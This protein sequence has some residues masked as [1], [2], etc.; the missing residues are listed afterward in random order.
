MKM[1]KFSELKAAAMAATPGPWGIN[2]AGNK[3]VSNQSHPVATV[4]DAFHRQ[5]A[6][7][8][9]GKDAEFI[10]AANPAAVLELL[11]ER[12]ADKKRIAELEHEK[13]NRGEGW[14]P[15]TDPITGS[16]FFMWIA[17]PDKGMVPTYGGPYDSYTLAERDKDGSYWVERY[18]HDNGC[19]RGQDM[20]IED[21][22]V[23]VVDD[24]LYVSEEDPDDLK[25]EITE[26]REKLA[27][28]VRLTDERTL[29][30]GEDDYDTGHVKGWNANR[31]EQAALLKKQGFTVE[32]DA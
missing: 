1:D 5:L 30:A 31:I 19:W 24:Q 22:G 3:I 7:G 20:G 32:G 10:A 13:G 14:R 27:T 23:Q 12:D 26:L 8:G 11:A 6:C 2:R 17:H 29:W 15:D 25:A 21:C 16:K 28:P 4:S 18:D 9:V